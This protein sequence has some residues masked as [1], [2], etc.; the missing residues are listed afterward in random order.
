MTRSPTGALLE[1]L[2]EIVHDHDVFAQPQLTVVPLLHRSTDDP[3]NVPLGAASGV[4]SAAAHLL[5]GPMLDTGTPQFDAPLAADRDPVLEGALPTAVQGMLG[6]STTLVMNYESGLLAASLVR[7]GAPVTATGGEARFLA[8]VRA[9]FSPELRT[10]QFAVVTYSEIGLDTRLRLACFRMICGLAEHPGALTSLRTLLV[11]IETPYEAPT[12]HCPAGVGARYLLREQR[13]VRRHEPKRLRS[14]VNRLVDPSRPLV[15][16]L[17]AGFSASSGLP[18]GNG[19][20]DATIARILGEDPTAK[21]DWARELFRRKNALLTASEQEDIEQFATT[22]TFEQVIRMETQHMGVPTP[23]AGLTEFRTLHD[24]ALVDEPG[25]AVRQLQALLPDPAKLILVT[26]NFDERIERDHTDQLDVIV[27][28][29]AFDEFAKD[30]LSKYLAGAPS[31]R[32]VPYLKLHGTISDLDTCVASS[33]ETGQGL[34]P[35]K[36]AAI[37]ALSGIDV[38][39]QWMYIGA[40]MRDIDLK[41]VFTSAGFKNAVDERWVAPFPDDNVAAFARTREDLLDWREVTLFERQ[42]TETAD[43]FMTGLAARWNP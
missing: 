18:V 6:P 3:P 16:F 25:A 35:G 10:A 28:D 4:L 14:E 19:L 38:P 2:T 22:L 1:A 33:R 37:M 27:S 9:L 17:G 24:A 40:S 7:R 30:G 8:L 26:V 21:L 31:P 41:P 5:G 36:E 34:K 23:P 12:V 20:R 15:L 42:I 13:V 39:V 29:E 32:K 43:V 11:A